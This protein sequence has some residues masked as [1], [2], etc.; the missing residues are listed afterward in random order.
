[1]PIMRNHRAS[2]RG[3]RVTGVV[4]GLLTLGAGYLIVSPP[5]E[6]RMPTRGPSMSP[7]MTRSGLVD[8]ETHAFDE[9]APAI[10]EVVVAQAPGGLLDGVCGTRQRRS[11]ACAGPTR[12][13]GRL[14]VLKRI[15]AGPGDTVAFTRRGSLIRNGERLSEPY[16]R[17]C[18]APVCG[19]PRPITVPAGHWF[20]AGDNRGNSS[21][22]RDWGPLPTAALDGR[23]ALP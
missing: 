19:L 10:G 17:A 21:D 7:T 13:Y 14:R 16:I 4:G 3:L 1:M 12:D 18:R 8:V 6:D 11:E 15:V 9:V 5:F 23:I 22:S 20:L 2:D